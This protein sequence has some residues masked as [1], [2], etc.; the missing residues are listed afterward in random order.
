MIIPIRC[1]TCG[2]IISNRWEFYNKK[3]QEYSQENVDV[4]LD[5][6]KLKQNKEYTPECRALNDCKLDRICC[7]RMFLTHVDL[8]NDI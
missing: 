3:V 2:K 4:Y 6:N 1:F 8:V 7:R 5:V